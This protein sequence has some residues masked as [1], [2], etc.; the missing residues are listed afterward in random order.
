MNGMRKSFELPIY[1]GKT[2]W[3][4]VGDIPVLSR[5]LPDGSPWP[6][7]SIITP[8]YNQAEY[9]EETIR[10]VL[11]QGYPNLE[12]IIVDGG[13]SDNSVSIIKKYERWLHYWISE[14]DRGQSHAINKGMAQAT[15]D[16]VAWINSDDYYVPFAFQL[17]VPFLQK[18]NWVL[19]MTQIVKSN[20]ELVA[21]I[22]ATRPPKELEDRCF[23]NKVSKDFFTAQPGHFWS[24]ALWNEIGPL[25]EKYNY[26]MDFEWM[27]RALATGKHPFFLSHTVAC[28]R[29]QPGAKTVNLPW[30]FD[31]DKA[32]IFFDLGCKG[33]LRWWPALLVSRTYGARGLRNQS[34]EVYRNGDKLSSLKFV[35]LAWLISP[36]KRGG[37]YWARVKRVFMKSNNF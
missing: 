10:S 20:G 4:W 18:N 16:I 33:V 35:V 8:S 28:L 36:Q 11:M 22:P 27:M 2:G 5:S 34:D 3:P 19:G 14:P 32:R 26:C 23:I 15:G 12:Y 6:K 31:L 7:I 17:A 30:E 29:Q 13:S 37:S 24:W 1:N 9:L 25:N 21:A